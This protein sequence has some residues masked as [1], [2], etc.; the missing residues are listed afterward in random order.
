MVHSTRFAHTVSP[1]KGSKQ[2]LGSG[3]KC[4]R[5][6]FFAVE[7]VVGLVLNA[8]SSCCQ[9]ARMYMALLSGKEF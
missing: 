7:K 4:D 3:S 1:F 6:C 5:S 8:L 2:M 9:S